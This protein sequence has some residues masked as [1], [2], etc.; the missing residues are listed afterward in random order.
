[1]NINKREILR[2]MGC[3]WPCEDEELIKLIDDT[4]C[5]AE[6]NVE[7]KSIYAFKEIKVTDDGAEIDGVFFKSRDIAKY[8][9]GCEKAV[10]MA[11]TLGVKS[12]FFIRIAQ[13]RGASHAVAAQAVL[14]EFIEKYCDQVQENIKTEAEKCGFMIK[15]R[16]SPGYGDL[17]I[18]YQ[19]EFFSVLDISRRIG[20][21]LSDDFIMS[22]SKSVTAIIGLKKAE[23]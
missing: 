6:K 4:V 23:V 20:I 8:L 17:D 21:S 13:S 7:P 14:T 22:P 15:P 1:M 3:N 12:D 10:L 19:K 18:R 2:Y 5:A 16:Y 9:G 11:C